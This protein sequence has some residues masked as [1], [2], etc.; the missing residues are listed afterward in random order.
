[1]LT[2][3]IKAGAELF[4]LEL[5]KKQYILIVVECGNYIGWR[6]MIFHYSWSIKSILWLKRL[7]KTEP[8]VVRVTEN[9]MKA[10]STWGHMILI[11][12]FT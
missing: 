11:F 1:M 9:K 8:E 6:D 3:L 5:Q 7:P 10:Q 4:R 12:I 2:S